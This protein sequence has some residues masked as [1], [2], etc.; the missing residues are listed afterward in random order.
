MYIL[1]IIISLA[2]LRWTVEALKK[3]IAMLRN[4]EFD[5]KEVDPDLHKRLENIL[6]RISTY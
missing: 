6:V 4:P 5:S 2:M 3:V 1:E